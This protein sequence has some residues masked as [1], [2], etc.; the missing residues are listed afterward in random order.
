[1]I[2]S[3]VFEETAETDSEQEPAGRII[4]AADLTTHYT[5]VWPAYSTQSDQSHT[6]ST[7][8]PINHQLSHKVNYLS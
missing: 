4:G 2:K 6:V 8:S 3:Q 7:T 5:L 1:M